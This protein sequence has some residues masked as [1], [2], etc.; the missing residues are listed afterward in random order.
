MMQRPANP[1][2]LLFLQPSANDS[3]SV[4]TTALDYT[5]VFNHVYQ[6]HG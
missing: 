4:L 2:G 6:P 3:K 5:S 1:P